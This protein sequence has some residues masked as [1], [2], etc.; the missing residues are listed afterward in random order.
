MKQGRRW[1]ND[2]GLAGCVVWASDRQGTDWR[3]GRGD[4]E[5]AD[6]LKVI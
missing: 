6:F 5:H 3:A 1:R 2:S 4:K